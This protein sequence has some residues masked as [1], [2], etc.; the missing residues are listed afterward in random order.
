MPFL[1]DMLFLSLYDACRHRSTAITDASALTDTV[2]GKLLAGQHV[3]DGT[4]Q[5]DDISTCCK[6]VLAAFDTTA[7]THYAAFHR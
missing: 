3:K 6:Q 2:I 5:R 4:V 7:A 1:R